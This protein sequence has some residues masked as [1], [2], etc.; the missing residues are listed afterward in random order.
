MTQSNFEFHRN[1]GSAALPPLV[2][3]V[4]RHDTLLGAD[5]YLFALGLDGFEVEEVTERGDGQQ[6]LCVSFDR[7]DTTQNIVLPRGFRAIVVERHHLFESHESVTGFSKPGWVEALDG[8]WA[9]AIVIGP[10]TKIRAAEALLCSPD[11]TSPHS[12]A[13]LLE[14]LRHVSLL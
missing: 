12:R 13:A 1:D 4:C 7:S 11:G 9:Q 8:D 6:V 5:A 2:E 3:V 10:E 14:H